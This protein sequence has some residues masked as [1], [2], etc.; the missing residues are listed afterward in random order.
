MER[1]CFSFPDPKELPRRPFRLVGISEGEWNI[2]GWGSVPFHWL[3]C[4]WGHWPALGVVALADQAAFGKWASRPDQQNS[5]KRRAPAR[6]THVL[7]RL[8]L[9]RPYAAF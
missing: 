1:L 6:T 3:V 7:V 9:E 2:T 8:T 4:G 5:Y